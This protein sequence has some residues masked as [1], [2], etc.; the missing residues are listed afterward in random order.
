MPSGN[1]T[2]S[3]TSRPVAGSRSWVI[4]Q[5]SMLT[6]SYPASLRPVLTNRSA[7]RSMRSALTLQ[8]NEFQSL[9]PIGGSAARP[10]ATAAAGEA[11]AAT[12]V[13]GA[14]GAGPP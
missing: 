7:V 14:G 4:Q 3:G 12:A 8:P 11:G 5:L 6:Y 2:G 13:I 1:F 10:S 9:N